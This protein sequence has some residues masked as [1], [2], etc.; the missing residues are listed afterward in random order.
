MSDRYMLET[1]KVNAF[2]IMEGIRKNMQPGGRIE[3]EFLPSIRAQ[4]ESGFQGIK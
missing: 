2:E 4:F 1:V 3:I